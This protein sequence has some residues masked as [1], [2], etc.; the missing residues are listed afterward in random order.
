LRHGQGDHYLAVPSARAPRLLVPSDVAGADRMLVRHAG[1]RRNRAARSALRAVHRSSLG[2]WAPMPRVRVTTDPAGIEH[3]VARV[4]GRPVRIGVLL[5]PPRA[6][7]K[8]VLQ[9][10]G[11]DGAVL[12]FAKVATSPVTVRLLRNEADA[13]QGLAREPL[14]GVAAPALLDIDTWRDLLV[15]VQTALPSAQTGRQPTTLPTAALAAITRSGGLRRASLAE[16]AFWGRVSDVGAP[17]WH[18]IDVSG[19]SRLRDAV[20]PA[21]ECL[22]GAWHGDFGPW[23]A[24]WGRT[25]LEVWDWERFDADVPAGMDAAH[26][27]VQLDVGTDPSSAWHSVRADVD[28]VL[29]AV[30]GSPDPSRDTA[31][32][33]ALVAA[34][35]VLAVW[36]RYRH[37]AADS[38]TAALRARVVW[39]CRLADAA[40]P[41][42]QEVRR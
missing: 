8:P 20:D 13:L 30:Q 18:G 24:A 3:H 4:L 21:G 28:E 9:V 33:S 40:L 19:V 2:S 5:G 42:L 27:R 23:N 1:G 34:C 39:L 36:A 25:E 16:S 10:F 17:S 7:L 26:W 35:Y 12:G 31:L 29:A 15:L 41:T 22:F 14:P 11:P 38:A 6:N 32:D 37:D